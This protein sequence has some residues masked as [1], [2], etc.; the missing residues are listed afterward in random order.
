[1]TAVWLHMPVRLTVGD[2]SADVGTLTLGPGDAVGPC[3]G[4]LLHRVAEEFETT[5]EGGNDG[6]A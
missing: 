2:H 1:M 4:R 6:S 5:Q 3:L